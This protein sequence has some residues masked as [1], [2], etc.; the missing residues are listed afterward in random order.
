MRLLVSKDLSDKGI[1]VAMA[2]FSG[3]NIVNKIAALERF[4]KE[5]AEKIAAEDLSGDQIL[6]E[7]S[8][9]QREAGIAE[10]IP[11]AQWLIEIT[12]RNRRLPNI[13]TV[14]DCYNMVS[15]ETYLSIGAHDL[16]RI[17]GNVRFV[18]TQGGER[19]T[20]LG[21]KEKE[22]VNAGEYACMDDEKILCRL[23]LKQCEETKITKDTKRFMVYV[24]GNRHAPLDLLQHAL[25]DVC[26]NI[27]TFCGGTY[28]IVNEEIVP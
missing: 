2:T 10:P 9:L 3:A 22:K 11:P 1:E 14:V 13:N 5:K 8:R 16:D 20:P 12:K 25:E 15:A 17:L 23:D 21:A 4:K 26:H 18:T 7:Y 24:Q 6:A 19:Y 28:E 27:T